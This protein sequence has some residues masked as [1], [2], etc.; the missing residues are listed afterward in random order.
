[1]TVFSWYPMI[2]LQPR[3]LAWD[4][5]SCL[6]STHQ[7]S[8]ASP[9]SLSSSSSNN[10][11]DLELTIPPRWIRNPG[12]NFVM[13]R[14]GNS[15]ISFLSKPLTFLAP[16]L[17]ELELPTLAPKIKIIH[18]KMKEISCKHRKPLLLTSWWSVMFR[19]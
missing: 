1:M 13:V 9:S 2:M 12:G 3:A 5:T 18:E 11:T 17:S 10:L 7:D 6:I 4:L 15:G 19:V 16:C 14:N 8:L